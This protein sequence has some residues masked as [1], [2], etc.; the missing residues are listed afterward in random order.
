MNVLVVGSGGREHA[1]AWKLAQSPS[2]EKIYAAPGNP[3]IAALD[4]GECLAIGVNDF[5]GLREAIAAHGV[6][7]VIVGPEDPLAA[8]IV[9]ELAMPDCLV[10]GPSAGA[11]R[12]EGSKAFAKEFM[13]KY[14]IPTAQFARFNSADAALVYVREQGAPIVIKADGLAAGKGVTVCK[15][16]AEA[17]A[18]IR[19]IM[20]DKAFGAAGEEVVIEECLVGEEASILAFC[21]G[22]TVIPMASSQDHKPAYDNDEGPNTGGMGAYSPAPVVNDAQMADIHASILQ[23]VVDGMAAEGT[24]YTGIL[25]AGLMMTQ[26]GPKVIEF[27]VRFGDP[28]TQ[29]VLPR[30]KNDIVPVF[31]ACCR[32]TLDQIDL[33][34]DP[35]AC[36]TVVMASGGYPGSYAKGIEITGIAEAEAGGAM[37]FHAG[38][39]TEGGSLRTNGGRVLNVT[40]KGAT[41]PEA[42]E[43]AYAAVGKIN[44]KD[45][46]YRNDIGKK[47]LKH[48]HPG[49]A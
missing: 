49:I 27:N 15:T 11:A 22:K 30:M 18:A 9:D 45:A 48:L 6:T 24:P 21:D 4:K 2:M 38:T 37:V 31:E 28:E 19:T 26:D 43:N 25:Y 47:A 13:A 5:E 41:I 20:V 39:K 32:G 46:H 36:V 17:E 40:A 42:I 35:A 33:A 34:Y 12:L 44:F 16:V 14:K 8:G 7:L 3:G 23:P 10:F 29:V 1:L